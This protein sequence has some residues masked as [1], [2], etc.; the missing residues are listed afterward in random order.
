MG[1][2]EKRNGRDSEGGGGK[3][4]REEIDKIQRRSMISKEDGDKMRNRGG[5]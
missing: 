3:K 4:A 5:G 2:K 1:G